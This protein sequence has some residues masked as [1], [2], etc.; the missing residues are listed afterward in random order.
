MKKVLSLILSLVIVIALLPAA[1]TVS[2][3]V[4]NDYYGYDGTVVSSKG[5]FENM[6][7]SD[8]T[9]AG[10]FMEG[11]AVVS[12]GAAHS[13][14]SYLTVA[15]EGKA[16]VLVRNLVPGGYMLRGY[17]KHMDDGTTAGSQIFME[18]VG[19][20][21]T[22][23]NSA[24]P[25]TAQWTRFGMMLNACQMG[26]NGA[27][28][29]WLNNGAECATLCLDDMELVRL[30]NYDKKNLVANPGFDINPAGTN[31]MYASWFNHS[32]ESE[33]TSDAY[34]GDT[35]LKIKSGQV[36]TW[37]KLPKANPAGVKYEFSARLK[38][39]HAKRYLMNMPGYSADSI[40]FESYVGNE[41]VYAKDYALTKQA[42]LS[43]PDWC[44]I[45]FILD[46]QSTP[47]GLVQ[48]RLF[49]RG[50]TGGI[51]WD[52]VSIKPVE[53]SLE[54]MDETGTKTVKWLE[55]GEDMALTVRAQHPSENGGKLFIAS[56][57]YDDSGELKMTNA[58]VTA[59]DKAGTTSACRLGGISA[60]TDSDVIVKAY[61]WDDA[62]APVA[63]TEIRNDMKMMPVFTDGFENT[64]AWRPENVA[65]EWVGAAMETGETHGG[66]KAIKLSGYNSRAY[67]K[68]G[69]L[70]PGNEYT[71]SL[72]YKGT[73]D[74]GEGLVIRRYDW[75][76]DSEALVYTKS[77]ESNSHLSSDEWTKVE[78][79]FTHY[80]G[81]EIIIGPWIKYSTGTIYFDDMELTR[82]HNSNTARIKTDQVFYYTDLT[83]NG[84]ASI[85]LEPCLENMGFTADVRLEKD[86]VTLA[87]SSGIEFT[88]NLITFEYDLDL[89]TEV[90]EEYRVV[91]DI[92]D[93]RNEIVDSVYQQVYR[94]DRPTTVS[95]DGTFTDIK[96]KRIDPVFM[97]HIGYDDFATAASAGINVMQYSPASTV[98]QTLAQLDEM[99]EMGVY[100]GVV[101]YWGMSPAG[102]IGNHDKVRD[103]IMQIK[104]HPAIFCYMIMDEPFLNNSNAYDDLRK[105][106]IMLRTADPARPTYICEGF[107][108]YM[109]E[110]AKYCDLLAPDIYPGYS[111]DSFATCV[112]TMMK[113]GHKY[114]NYD[115]PM[116]TILQAFTQNGHKPT[117][118]ELHSMMYQS[119]LAGGNAVGFYTW[120]PDNPNVDK[121]ICDDFYWPMLQEFYAN[122][123]QVV[124]DYYAYGKGTQFNKNIEDDSNVWYEGWMDEEGKNLYMVIQNRLDDEELATTV[125]LV[126]ADG[127]TTIANY[128]AS[129]P[130][131]GEDSVIEDASSSDMKVTLAPCQAV[132]VKITLK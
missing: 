47:E 101:C 10:W 96:G 52:D 40:G 48:F 85:Q 132:L 129:V 80:E 105:S 36:Y 131:F 31:T 75:A 67:F 115:K 76:N 16:G 7:I 100:A 35:A 117:A 4:T 33:I 56:Y 50:G 18:Q 51:I 130:G 95:K 37:V 124:Y 8:L 11:G 54:F 49:L 29:V 55:N 34:N 99:Y 64:T 78:Y 62:N 66:S 21:T 128:T 120:E 44:H 109:K 125:P 103:F 108:P 112:G 39:Q 86:G 104:H 1:V 97:Y 43:G 102:S 98:E 83:G 79:T 123:K 126:S 94:F 72:W 24:L 30:D 2:A 9:G 42:G 26:E 69:G 88:E 65:L 70:L 87:E 68:Y 90:T 53:T 6:S 38:W 82:T 13:G 119:L 61:L 91:A 46:E 73:I 84:T 89:M 3:A 71:F 12:E 121:K 19:F 17:Y 45:K 14:S 114:V 58:A 28:R 77:Y 116:L 59:V 23:Y 25:Y 22:N 60:S 63:E 127:K 111:H 41:V 107:A 93:G 15:P 110:V 118:L 20:T 113:L 74:S 32:G 106:Y 5:N 27:I 81:S 57:E 92:K 122:E